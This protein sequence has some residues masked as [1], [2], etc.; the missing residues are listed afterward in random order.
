M[1]LSTA[2]NTA[3]GSTSDCATTR[4]V[5]ADQLDQGRLTARPRHSHQQGSHDS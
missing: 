2:M 4:S 1:A 5:A 3:M